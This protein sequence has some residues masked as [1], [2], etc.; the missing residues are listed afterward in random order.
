[1]DFLYGVVFT[2]ALEAVG[3]IFATEWIRRKM[4]EK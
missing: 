1:M 3:L 4:N 2:L